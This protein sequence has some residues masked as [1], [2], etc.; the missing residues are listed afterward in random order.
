LS[1]IESR[2]LHSDDALHSP[3]M[4]RLDPRD[5][6]LVTEIVYG[7]LRWRAPLDHVLALQ[8]ARPWAGIDPTIRTLLRMSLYQM[9]KMDRVPDH[10]ICND[11]VELARRGSR[12]GSDRLV[13]GILRSLGRS[14]PWERDDFLAGAPGWVRVSLPRWLYQRWVRRYGVA[15]AEEYA[16]S[17][18]A[19]PRA[20]F[21][22]GDG[23]GEGET[24]PGEPSPL[25]PGA[26]LATEEVPIKGGEQVQDEAS[27][28]MPHL[29]GPAGQRGRAWDACAAPGGKAAILGRIFERVVASDISLNRVRR[30]RR[31][32]GTEGLARVGTIVADAGGPPPFST[33]FEA[34]LADVPCSGLGTL[35]RNPEIKWHFKPEGFAELGQAQARILG[36]V[37]R[38]VAA[39]GRLLYTTCSTEPEE[40]ER[41]VEQFLASHPDF[42]VDPPLYPRGVAAWTGPDGFVRTFPSVRRWDGFFA[43]LMRRRG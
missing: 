30:M 20:A 38:S 10:A 33:E 2:R 9:W 41:V 26:L 29:F 3:A 34:V 8:S 35:R 15:Q 21:R 13:N 14:R 11:A 37:A 22:P 5:R 42:Q 31:L 40:N 16:L 25:V 43:A 23:A 36:S 24:P 6:R 28:L 1:R 39:G 27:Q 4:E 19:P 18:N 32:A 17:L 12:G 7:T